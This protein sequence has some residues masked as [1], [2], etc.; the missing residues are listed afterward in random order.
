MQSLE[1]WI[2][3]SST[4]CAQHRLADLLFDESGTQSRKIFFAK[5]K[6]GGA[7]A[8][9]QRLNYPLHGTWWT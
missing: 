3:N 8:G 9:S 4:K 2:S 5:I 7:L 1:S 6:G